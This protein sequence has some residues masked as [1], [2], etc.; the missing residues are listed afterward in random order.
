MSE[1][2]AAQAAVQAA[3]DAGAVYAD[4]RVM[5]RRYE[6]MTAR[7]GEVEDLGQ[8]ETSGIGVR[9]LVGSGWGFYAVPDLTDAA[10][11]AA[12]AQATAIATSSSR[13]AREASGLI[14]AG[15]ASVG[16]WASECVVDPLGVSL[17][18]KGDMLVRASAT[19]AEHGADIAEAMYQ[20]WDTAKWFVSS[21]GH[22]IDQRVRECGAGIMATSIGDG[23]T[24]RRSYPA[25]RGQYGTR[26]LGDG[27]R[28][29]TSRPT[30]RGSPT[31][32]APCCRR[33]RARAARRR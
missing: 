14:P 28:R 21:E 11:R 10:V 32:P 19:M 7:N 17:A 16:S 27:R 4:A 15:P 6:S 23:E 8:D 30:R 2:D 5:H 20:I 3:L 31:S 26:G 22:R 24:Q 29:S 33:H 13:V 1:F 25:A 9:A 12:G 18:D